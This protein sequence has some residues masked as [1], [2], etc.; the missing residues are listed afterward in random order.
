M[1]VY[2]IRNWAL[3]FE[4]A[5]SLKRKKHG[6]WVAMPNK[7]DGRGYRRIMTEAD[8]RTIYGVW[9]AMV[10]VA[11]KMPVRGLLADQDGP[12]SPDDIA[13]KIGATEEEV[14]RAIAVVTNP[15][16]DWLEGLGWDESISFDANMAMLIKNGRLGEFRFMAAENPSRLKGKSGT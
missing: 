7:H 9:C 16:I 8:G 1:M 6:S 5:E 15:R 13:T 2:V 14:E 10:Q 4:T 12:L 11:S 3:H